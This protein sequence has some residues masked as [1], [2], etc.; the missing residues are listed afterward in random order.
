M[1]SSPSLAAPRSHLRLPPRLPSSSSC[2]RRLLL[3]PRC[4][5]ASLP[6][7]ASEATLYEVLGVPT[8]ATG[9][10]IK[11]AYRRLARECHPD[12][13]TATESS[14]EFIRL[15]AAYATLSDPEKRAEYDQRVMAATANAAARRRWSPR[16]SYSCRPCRRWETDQCW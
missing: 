2:R 9:G 14:D 7:P 11:V 3:P 6:G 15:H 12:V 8:G 13:A 4:A 1:I 16:R 10:E 5:S